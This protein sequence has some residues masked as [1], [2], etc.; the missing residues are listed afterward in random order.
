MM[1]EDVVRC[2]ICLKPIDLPPFGRLEG[3][4]DEFEVPVFWANCGFCGADFFFEQGMDEE[5]TFYQVLVIR[6]PGLRWLMSL[7]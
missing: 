6:H 4:V 3:P 7:V 1:N 2:P 5:V